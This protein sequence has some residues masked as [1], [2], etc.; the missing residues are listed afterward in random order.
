MKWHCQ[1]A[2][3]L[4][5]IPSVLG[6]GDEMDEEEPA[7]ASAPPQNRY[8]PYYKIK[9]ASWIISDSQLKLLFS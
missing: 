2:R 5:V 6:I 3:L 8:R 7:L 4:T 1:P 9:L